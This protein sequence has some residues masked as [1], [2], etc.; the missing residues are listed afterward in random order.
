MKLR[1]RLFTISV[2]LWFISSAAIGSAADFDWIQDFNIRAEADP[3][4]FRARL[5]VRFKTGDV[6]INAVLSHVKSPADAYIVLCLGEMSS[7]PTDYVMEKYRREKGKGWGAVAKSLGV[8]PGSKEF[9][10]LKQGS[11]L[12]ENHLI[13]EAKGKGKGKR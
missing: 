4:G 8:K 5:A 13:R 7:K 6:E 12:Y 1:K 2:I 9:H 10:A 11:D 3:S